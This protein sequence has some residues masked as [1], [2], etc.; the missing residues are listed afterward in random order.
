MKAIEISAIR[1]LLSFG[2]AYLHDSNSN[3][4][5]AIRDLVPLFSEA[6]NAAKEDIDILSIDLIESLK[7]SL[8]R[9]EKEC[10]P[11]YVSKEAEKYL[12][13]LIDKAKGHKDMLVAF[14]AM[15]P[16]QSIAFRGRLSERTGKR[17]FVR[18][19]PLPI[20]PGDEN[21]VKGLAK[22][23]LKKG[24]FC[25]LTKGAN[26]SYTQVVYEIVSQG[27]TLVAKRL[28]CTVLRGSS[29]AAYISGCKAA[30]SGLSFR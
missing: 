27:E 3:S 1:M 7:K 25:T 17:L 26:G 23:S 5:K 30:L 19:T 22:K 10:R 21:F 18:S 4:I 24:V 29:D 13:S 14:E 16:G 28:Q 9:A 2:R 8:K 12:L 11:F 15:A 20:F 6:A